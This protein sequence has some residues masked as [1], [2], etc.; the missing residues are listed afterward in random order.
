MGLCSYPFYFIADANSNSDIYF[1]EVGLEK[2]TF[3]DM[4]VSESPA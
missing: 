3:M 4:M 2:K 1:W